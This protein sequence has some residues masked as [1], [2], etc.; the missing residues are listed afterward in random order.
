M[1]TGQSGPLT[2]WTC[3]IF[4]TNL[5]KPVFKHQKTTRKNQHLKNQTQPPATLEATPQSATAEQGLPSLSL[6]PSLRLLTYPFV[7]SP[8]R[9]QEAL[10]PVPGPRNEPSNNLL[11]PSIFCQEVASHLSRPS[12]SVTFSPTILTDALQASCPEA[13]ATSLP[14]FSSLT[15]YHILASTHSTEEQLTLACTV[16]LF[17]KPDMKQVCLLKGSRMKS[18]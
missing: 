8:S 2:D 3:T 4:K 13:S 12:W 9:S 15:Q 14:V 11:H 7:P 16:L 5:S 1:P 17:P 10:D 6:T 18:L